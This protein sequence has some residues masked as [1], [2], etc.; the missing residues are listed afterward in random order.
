MS[1]IEV[2]IE[3]I[4]GMAKGNEVMCA[5][6]IGEDPKSVSINGADYAVD[7][8]NVDERD[9]VIYLTLADADFKNVQTAQEEDDDEPAE[10]G[11]PDNSGE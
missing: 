5:N 6:S 1:W 10:G 8:W 3:G 2:E 11:N 4:G 7:D 9:D